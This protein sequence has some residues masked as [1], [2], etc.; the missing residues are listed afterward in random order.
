MVNRETRIKIKG[1]I[2]GFIQG[3]IEET[4]KTGF[5]PKKPRPLR[6][7]ST[8]GNIKPFHEA[9]L[10]DGILRVNEFERSF[11]TKLGS[12]FEEAAKLIAEQ[13]HKKAVRG[14]RLEGIISLRAIKYWPFAHF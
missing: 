3:I 6:T 11:S 14:Y 12:T 8:E 10:P 7:Q 5:D 1:Y 13:H 2:E 4:V 9:L